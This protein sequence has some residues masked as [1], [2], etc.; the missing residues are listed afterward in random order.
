MIEFSEFQKTFYLLKTTRRKNKLY[1][2]IKYIHHHY[3]D[4]LLFKKHTNNDL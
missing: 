2:N 3:F 4:E 1:T